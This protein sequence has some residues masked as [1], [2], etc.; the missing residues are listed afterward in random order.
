VLLETQLARLGAIVAADSACRVQV[1][2]APATVDFVD[3]RDEEVE[4]LVAR[5]AGLIYADSVL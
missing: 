5:G 3:T 2:V 1:V 4:L